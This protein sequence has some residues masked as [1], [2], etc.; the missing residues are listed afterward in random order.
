MPFLKQ[1]LVNATGDQQ[2]I[3]VSSAGVKMSSI[4][5]SMF[6]IAGPAHPPADEEVTSF[7][8]LSS[9]CAPLFVSKVSLY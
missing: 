1:R 4:K 8:T 2:S 6:L 5:L 7:V 3:Q 9:F